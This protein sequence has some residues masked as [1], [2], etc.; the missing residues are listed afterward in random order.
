M[1]D[2]Q[3][4]G[5]RIRCRS[6]EQPLRVPDEPAGEAVQPSRKARPPAR[7][8]VQAR[9]KMR[10]QAVDDDAEEARPR[11]RQPAAGGGGRLWL[12]GAGGL[13]CLVVC[14]VVI[15]ASIVGVFL[16][17]RG[18]APSTEQAAVPMNAPAD[19][20]FNNDPPEPRNIPDLPNLD[21]RQRPSKSPKIF[22]DP[23]PFNDPGPPGKDQPAPEKP[24]RQPGTGGQLSPEVLN[25]V[26]KATT[27]MRVTLA[28]NRVGEG[29]GFFA[30]Q[31][32]LVLT[33]AHVVGMLRPDQPPPTKVEVTLQ[34]G[35]PDARTMNGIV[36]GVDRDADLALVR[37]T[38]DNL[39]MPLD[40]KAVGGLQLTQPVFIFGFPFGEQLGKNVTVSQTSV[41]SLRLGPTGE[42]LQVQV[43][44][45]MHPG[46][47]GGP[48]VD[49][50]GDIVGIAVAGIPGTQ[51]NF[52]VPCESLFKLLSGRLSGVTM[53]HS[54]KDGAGAKVRFKVEVLDPL[55]RVQKLT[56]TSWVGGKAPRPT[57]KGPA[58]Q[59][60]GDGPRQETDLV[61]QG[62]RAVTDLALPTLQGDQV[63]WV[64][65]MLVNSAGQTQWLPATPFKPS[66]PLEAEAVDLSLKT[67][68]GARTLQVASKDTMHVMEIGKAEKKFDVNMV[69]TMVETPAAASPTSTTLLMNYRKYEVGVPTKE[70]PPDGHARIKAAVMNAGKLWATLI[71]DKNNCV[72]DNRVDVK[73]VA[74]DSQN[75]LAGLHEQI[76]D[77]LEMLSVPLLGRVVQ[78][79]EQWKAERP[80]Y[81]FNGDRGDLAPM[82]VTYT[83]QGTELRKGRKEAVLAIEAVSTANLGRTTQITGRV[84]GQAR[85]DVALGQIVLADVTARLDM[86]KEGKGKMS[87]GLIS[88]LERFLGE[89]VLNVRGQLTA[90]SNRNKE[91][92]LF[93]LHDVEFEQ[94]KTYA[95]GVEAVTGKAPF[96]VKITVIDLQRNLGTSTSNIDVGPTAVMD[97]TPPVAGKHR[98]MVTSHGVE[99]TGNYLLVV[100]RLN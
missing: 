30:M 75:D 67:L 12:W 73:R 89:E 18:S 81:V 19:L 79:G 97:Y 50:D 49:H 29:S 22:Q 47:S 26:K 9:E 6:C 55:K 48:V 66:A 94:G 5:K 2:D 98:V 90:K 95:V 58:G 44:G 35:E 51:I 60:P 52:A 69:T 93:N 28:D 11:R 14:G 65:P 61:A 3:L 63:L 83:F 53:G 71:V 41:S 87:A 77:S 64:Q 80:L 91:N 1:V 20:P 33:N 85:F 100:R 45:G 92:Q 23:P 32:G 10:A 72:L 78:P 84:T 57:A 31:R 99:V 76:Q 39:P 74:A 21:E 56:L 96:D 15:I 86:D 17:N 24:K 25:M 27:H 36:I 68:W 82:I 38:E 46:N 13:G 88:K 4:C 40:V 34:S 42:L 70:I 16:L 62:G 7:E 37:V 43:N 8:S 54:F 59:R